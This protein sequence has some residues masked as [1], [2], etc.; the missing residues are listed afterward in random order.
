MLWKLQQTARCEGRITLKQHVDNCPRAN[1]LLGCE[2]NRKA[3]PGNKSLM[4]VWIINHN[5]DDP[6]IY[7]S[8]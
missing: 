2:K 1:R 5:G 6:E 8:W 3:G 7:A 4:Y